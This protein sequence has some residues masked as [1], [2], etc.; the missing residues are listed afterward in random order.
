MVWGCRSWVGV[1][2]L[3]RIDGIMNSQVYLNI[4]DLQLLD[5]IERQGLDE[6][7]IIFQ[8]DNDPKHTSNLVQRWLSR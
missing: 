7:D 5:T 3:Y 2:N 6:A 4:L 1:G 8:H